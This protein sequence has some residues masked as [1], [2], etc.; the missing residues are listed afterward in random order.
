MIRRILAAS[1]VVLTI[2]V[3]FTWGSILVLSELAQQRDDAA[4][5]PEDR[6]DLHW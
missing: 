5:A 1:A 2:V 6:N 4:A 3:P